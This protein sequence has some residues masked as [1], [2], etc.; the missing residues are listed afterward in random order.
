MPRKILHIDLDAFFCA[1]EELKQPA[2]RGQ[3]FAVGGRPE[4]RG[5]VASCSYAAR[6]HGVRSAMSMKQA[7]QRCPQL[8]V[9]PANHA[10]YHR[11][12]RQVMD[13]LHQI[14]A[15]VEQVSIDEA[16]LEISDLP[17]RAEDVARRLQA[18]INNELR[19]PCSIGVAANKLVAKIANDVGKAEKRSGQPPNAIKVVPPGAE[20]G[21]LAEQP[22]IALW[23]VGPKTAERLAKLKIFTIGDLASQGES[24]LV[25]L[26]GKHGRDLYRYACGL[27]DSPIVTVHEPKSFSQET[28][29]S[30]DTADG[31]KLCQ[32]L[33]EM[34]E[35]IGRQL[36][37]R[38][39][40]GR[41]VKIKLRW[42]D[43]TTITRQVT[44]PHPTDQDEEIFTA[45]E[46]LFNQNWKPGTLVRLVG[47]G[48][49]GFDLQPT[50]LSLWDSPSERQMRLQQAVDALRQKYGGDA[51]KKGSSKLK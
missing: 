14:T 8:L 16:F 1:V 5:V 22:A 10:E 29:F 48:V 36:R 50:Q 24:E 4:E 21:F 42:R 51:I 25:G 49:S 19:L 45:V 47:V 40:R 35:S 9:L 23:G 32:T 20:A 26:F 12:S 46:H 30:R 17:E 7:L 18:Q 11:V 31:V 34:A 44:L 6:V 28:T 38:E 15:Q 3:P 41:T 39:L 43:F 37:E 33:K 13:R 27:D 2:L